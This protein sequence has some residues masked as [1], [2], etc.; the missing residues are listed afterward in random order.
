MILNHS[1]AKE[2]Q[3]LLGRVRKQGFKPRSYEEL[4]REA[5]ELYRD[6]SRAYQ[7]P[8]PKVQRNAAGLLAKRLPMA[9]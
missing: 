6:A 7:R 4:R 9:R 8:E 1:A 2:P 5:E 3:P